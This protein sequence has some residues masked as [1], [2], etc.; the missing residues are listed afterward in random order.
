MQKEF[1]NLAEECR[2]CTRYGKNAKFLIP[3]NSSK[4]LP[5]LSQ[6]GQEVQLD[7]AGPLEHYKG[8]N[9]F[10]KSNR[11]ILHFPSVKITKLT[12]VKSSIKFLRSYID[13]H[14]IPESIKTDQLSGF[15]RKAMKKFCLDNNNEQKFCPVGDH[16]VCG[17]VEGT[18][19]TIKRRLGVMLLEE[20]G[21]SIKLCLGTIIRD[22]RWTKK[23]TIQQSPFEALFGRPPKTE[24]KILGDKFLQNSNHLVK[25]HLERS[26]LTANQL[27]KRID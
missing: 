6:P 17:L 10:A 7:Y 24:I 20:N 9:L 11:Q 3:K 8:K 23:K 16:R 18:I 2:A 19:Q 13:S 27:K 26:A 1:V 14:G 12:G 22:M 5:L 4:P 15:K 25:Q 21:K